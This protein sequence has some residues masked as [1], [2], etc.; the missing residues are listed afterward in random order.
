MLVLL[1]SV[2][3][4]WGQSLEDCYPD[5][6][7]HAARSAPNA[8]WASAWPFSR[9]PFTASSRIRDLWWTH[10]LIL[11][12][13]CFECSLYCLILN[14]VLRLPK[15]PTALPGS[16]WKL[17]SPSPPVISEPEG[18][19]GSPPHSPLLLLRHCSS[20]Q[21]QKLPSSEAQ[22]ITAPPPSP[23]PHSLTPSAPGLPLP[24]CSCH[25]SW[26]RSTVTQMTPPAFWLLS[27]WPL[28]LSLH[29]AAVTSKISNTRIPSSVYNLLIDRAPM[30]LLCFWL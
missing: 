17:L 10:S 18:G 14:A 29:F 26:W 15:N 24:T 27:L 16:Q 1:F 22:N 12:M 19:K 30:P 25:H 13:S 20:S 21:V 5:S 3:P 4:G 2:T 8:P 9:N 23:L 7:F 11:P 6:H 28:Y